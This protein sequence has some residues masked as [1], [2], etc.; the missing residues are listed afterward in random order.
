MREIKGIDFEGGLAHAI[1]MGQKA[2]RSGGGAAKGLAVFARNFALM[3]SQAFGAAMVFMLAKY[4]EE[5]IRLASSL[6][7]MEA[8]FMKATGANKEF[9]RSTTVA[10][11][12]TRRF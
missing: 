8:G 1:E 4:T 11:R 2:A 3:F 9:A 12:E 7:D 6:A 5:A 10:F